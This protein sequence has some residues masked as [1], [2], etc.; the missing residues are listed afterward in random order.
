MQHETVPAFDQLIADP[1]Q[2]SRLSLGVL[3]ALQTRCAA[4]LTVIATAISDKVLQDAGRSQQ[5]GS[6][7]P[8]DADQIAVELGQSRRWVFRNSK[9]LP[10]VRRISRKAL[11][12]SEA[13][14]RRWKE[15]QKY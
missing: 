13:A 2:V 9:K 6:D 8:L 12:C 5:A 11:V 10:F 15:A 7:R 14:L 1:S 4:A 3:I